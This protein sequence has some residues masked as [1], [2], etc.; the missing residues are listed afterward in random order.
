MLLG[1]DTIAVSAARSLGRAGIAVHA[2]G[3]RRWDPVRRSRYC[4]TFSDVG[5]PEEV[6]AR[7]LTWFEREGPGGGVVLPCDD[8]GLELVARERARL[9]ELGY[10][11]VE[12]N[13][14]VLLAMLDKDEQY[15]LAREVGVP[16][17]H[18]VT[19]RDEADVE[20]AVAEIGLPCALKPLHSHRF[21]QHFGIRKKV[22][23]VETSAELERELRA[24]VELD[25][26][27]LATEIVTGGDHEFA[28]YYTY[29]DEDGE[30]LFHFTKRKIRQWPTR[31]G[32][33]CYQVTEWVPEVAELGLRFFQGVGLR[34][35]G[36]VEFKRDP[37]DGEWKLIECNHRFTA[38]NELVRAAGIEL[39]LLAYN[40]VLG[41]P[42]PRIRGF[43]EGVRM[44]H[45]IED[46]RAFRDYRRNGELT[47]AQWVASLLHRQH[48]PVLTLSDPLPAAHNYRRMARSALRKARGERKPTQTPEPLAHAARL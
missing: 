14:D 23:V 40:R 48:F 25:L 37:R 18:T 32:L 38:A 4:T 29:V 21:A 43:R 6:Q 11:P 22:V 26:E 2:L 39:P 3:N 27:M 12:A 1:G 45:A 31:F 35:V 16:V 7:Y 20:R 47:A 9:V 15:R 10:A 44:W 46:F 42:G 13:D 19:V 28:S 41:R 8:E 17:P 34:G 24:L 30:P 5:D 33:T 36:N